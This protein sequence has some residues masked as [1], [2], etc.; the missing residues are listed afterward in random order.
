MSKTS[1]SHP[2]DEAEVADDR[3]APRFKRDT[4]AVFGH[5]DSYRP[6]GL[7]GLTSNYY[8]LL[9]AA[10]STLEGLVFGGCL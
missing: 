10:F 9:C 5:R 3:V 7:R 6:S 8:V 1:G 2:N 4:E